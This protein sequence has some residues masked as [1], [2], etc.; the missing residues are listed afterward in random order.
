MNFKNV[1]KFVKN[2]L[3]DN[4]S[5]KFSITHYDDEACIIY[6]NYEN[7]RAF[8]I[9]FDSRSIGVQMINSDCFYNRYFDYDCGE[10]EMNE[11]IEDCTEI[12]NCIKT[13]IV[14]KDKFIE[15]AKMNGL[16]YEF[17]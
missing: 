17:I 9:D 8:S 1:V 10:N 7:L 15:V 11:T 4:C 6:V 16:Y 12:L 14:N 5:S 3:S 13:I 2:F